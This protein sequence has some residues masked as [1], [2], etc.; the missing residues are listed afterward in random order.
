MTGGYTPKDDKADA[1]LGVGVGPPPPSTGSESIKPFEVNSRGGP[2]K[3]VRTP[4]VVKTV[5]S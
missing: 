4:D 2:S 1:R 3:T 5:L